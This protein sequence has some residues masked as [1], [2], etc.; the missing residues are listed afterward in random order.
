MDRPFANPRNNNKREEDHHHGMSRNNNRYSR[1]GIFTRW[2]K[3]RTKTSTVDGVDKVKGWA[4]WGGG[5]GDDASSPIMRFQKRRT[6]THKDT[7][8]FCHGMAYLTG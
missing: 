6:K 8:N 1:G 3:M 2:K 7:D 4:G 5:G